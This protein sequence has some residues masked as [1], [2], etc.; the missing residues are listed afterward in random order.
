M[1]NQSIQ[2]LNEKETQY[3]LP[4]VETTYP[5]SVR[6]EQSAKGARVSVHVYNIHLELAVK[7]AIETYLILEDS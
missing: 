2:E 6:I 5:Y 7:E 3:P 1:L 4:N